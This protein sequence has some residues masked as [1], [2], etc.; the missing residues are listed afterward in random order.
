MRL[1]NRALPA[2]EIQADMAA[3]V[4]C[5]GPTLTVTPASLS[6]SGVAGGTDPAAKTLTVASGSA[7]WTASE[8]APWLSLATAGGTITAHRAARRPRRRHAHDRHHGHRAGRHGIA[9]DDPG[10]LHRRPAAGLAVAPASLSFSGVQGGAD[11]AS[12]TLSVSNTGGGSLSFSV[13]DDAPW[14]SVSPGERRRA[15]DADRERVDG[16]AVAG[17]VHG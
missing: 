14:L 7:S 17:Y 13:S 4:T 6:F 16:R 9:E 5:S 12:K 2:G 10:H 11:P 1:Y 8:S 3:P 15:R